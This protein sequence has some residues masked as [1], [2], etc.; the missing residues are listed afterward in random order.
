MKTT[1]VLVADDNLDAALSLALLLE[2]VDGFEVRTANDGATAV[3]TARAWQPHAALLDLDMP[4]TDGLEACQMIR[5]ACPGCVMVALSGHAEAHWQQ[6]AVDVGFDQ[7][8]LKGVPFREL[9]MGLEDALMTRQ[10]APMSHRSSKPGR[11]MRNWLDGVMSWRAWS[12]T[13]E[14]VS[15]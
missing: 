14:P 3:E 13:A 6:R 11:R 2:M 12:A 10:P 5:T 4:V 1:R 15:Q 8:H 7:Y 9:R